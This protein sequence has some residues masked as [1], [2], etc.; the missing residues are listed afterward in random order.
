VRP[1]KVGDGAGLAADQPF[2]FAGG[3][4][5]P[6]SHEY[7]IAIAA[8][9]VLKPDFDTTFTR[10]NRP[11]STHAVPAAVAVVVGETD[12]MADAVDTIAR[13]IAESPGIGQYHDQ[14][15]R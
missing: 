10:G 7:W 4:R 8:L 12:V 14:P 1:V 6:G 9:R 15:A 13:L 11:L 5:L 3:A 2:S